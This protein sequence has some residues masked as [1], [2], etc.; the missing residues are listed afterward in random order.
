[1]AEIF[2]CINATPV[3]LVSSSIAY[4]PAPVIHIDVCEGEQVVAAARIMHPYHGSMLDSSINK[5]EEEL[6]LAV[7]TLFS[8]GLLPLTLG[9]VME[10]RQLMQSIG[11]H[12]IA[13]MYQHPAEVDG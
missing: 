7:L 13:P 5:A 12:E 6:E 9:R 3:K 4:E 11:H 1:M 8:K 2:H 10:L